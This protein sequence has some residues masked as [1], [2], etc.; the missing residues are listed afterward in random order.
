MKARG[1]G[2][3]EMDASLA[4]NTYNCRRASNTII[5]ANLSKYTE[6]TLSKT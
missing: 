4:A 2:F 3:S 5:A 1:I 6:D